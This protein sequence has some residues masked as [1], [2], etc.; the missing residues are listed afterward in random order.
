M[1]GSLVQAPTRQSTNLSA[2]GVGRN[3]TDRGKS[4][5]KIHLL[6]DQEGMPYGV[7]LAGAN[8]H[9]SRLV[10]TTIEGRALPAPKI[11]PME[12][13]PTKATATPGCRH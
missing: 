9:D 3:P 6:T 1:D 5:S 12:E 7:A 10:T 11:N 4:G 8:I 2:E 13:K